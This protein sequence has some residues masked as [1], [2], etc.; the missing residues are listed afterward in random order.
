[1]PEV[2]TSDDHAINRYNCTV[3]AHALIRDRNNAFDE[4]V[5]WAIELA[6]SRLHGRYIARTHCDDRPSPR[7]LIGP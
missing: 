6:R 1:M 2:R 5:T 3:P 7:R 4:P